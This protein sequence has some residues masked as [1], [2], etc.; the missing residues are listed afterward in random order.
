MSQNIFKKPYVLLGPYLYHSPKKIIQAFTM[1]DIPQALMDIDEATANGYHVAG[2]LSFEVAQAFE[3]KLKTHP[4]ASKDE[5][6]IWM[7]VCETPTKVS[8]KNHDNSLGED[9]NATLTLDKPKNIQATYKK[10]FEKIQTYIQAGDVYQINYTFELPL[11]ITGSVPFLYSKLC[12]AQPVEF[13]ALIQ[14]P[15][16]SVLSLSPELFLEKKGERVVTRPMKGTAPRDN[17]NTKDTHLSLSLQKDSKNRAENLMIVDL[18]RNDLS[19]IAT[20]GSVKV[21]KLFEIEK[22]ETLF[23]MTSTISA[24]VDKE[25]KPSTLLSALFPCGSVTGAPKIRAMEIIHE[26]EANAR[27]VYCGAIGQFSPTGDI[28][29]NVPIRT[30]LVQESGD[31]RL[32]VGSGIVADSVM[33][34]EL[35]ECFLK[36]KFL[37]SLNPPFDLIETLLW[38]KE[39]G[40]Q[41]LEGH[42]NRLR[43]S[44]KHFL[45]PFEE[46]K[47]NAILLHTIQDEAGPLRIRITLSHAGDINVT[48]TDWQH[49][50]PNQVPIV[51]FAKTLQKSDNILLQHKTSWRDHYDKERQESVKRLG[52]LDIIF[53]NDRGE[54]TEGAISNIFIQKEDTLY[55]PPLSCGVLPGVMR[56]TLL[57]DTNCKVEE[58]VLTKADVLSADAIFLSNSVRGLIPVQLITSEDD[59]S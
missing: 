48:K 42:M 55:T 6:L 53:S 50:T 37:S 14:T 36:A 38:E 35:D 24:K 26:L 11:K 33:A 22:Y 34:E 58:K 3:A 52:V 21:E 56:E 16:F 29:L 4:Q 30:I 13:S 32:N 20:D 44:A 15:T 49:S 31:A 25:I 39:T 46:N 27:G 43:K 54:I 23:Q 59:I 57:K 41:R 1:E 19:K 45:R 8:K 5:P 51:T 18:L 47:L 40:F 9:V 7:V 28:T 10:A 2:W 17:N 12:T